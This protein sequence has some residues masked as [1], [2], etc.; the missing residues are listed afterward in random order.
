MSDGV[1]NAMQMKW[2]RDCLHWDWALRDRESNGQS[3]THTQVL[4]LLLSLS[5]GWWF[6]D[7]RETEMWKSVTDREK[8][9]EE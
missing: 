6:W 3:H 5:L 1:E 2:M 9:R 8:E 7:K 4:S